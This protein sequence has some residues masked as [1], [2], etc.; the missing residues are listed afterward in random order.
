MPDT[1]IKAALLPDLAVVVRGVDALEG[2]TPKGA[3]AFGKQVDAIGPAHERYHKERLKRLRALA[4]K[5]EKGN[6]IT[7]VNGALL[8]FDFG[9]GF[10]VV[11]DTVHA[12]LAELNDEDITLSGVRMVKVAELGTA[13][14][15]PAQSRVLIAAKLLEDVEPE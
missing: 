5:D 14:L 3:Y 2:A 15:T 7:Q 11:P 4:K 9:E 8:I 1:T 13:K 10:G 12:A 6:P